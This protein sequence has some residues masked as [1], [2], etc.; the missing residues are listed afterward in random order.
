MAVI[1]RGILLH[2]AAPP[3]KSD[4]NLVSKGQVRLPGH[5]WCGF[6]AASASVGKPL[7]AEFRCTSS[8]K[9][10]TGA[11]GSPHPGQQGK[12]PAETLSRTQERDPRAPSDACGFSTTSSKDS[13]P[14]TCLQ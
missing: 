10:A 6:A 4:S 5:K 2:G 9:E 11:R 1:F 14:A 13:Q 3:D 12:A 8:R 7:V